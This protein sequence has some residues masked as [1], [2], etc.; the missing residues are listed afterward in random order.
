[1]QITSPKSADSFSIS[2][3]A[4]W[5]SL[6]VQTD[7]T[8]SHT[9]NWTIKWG[10]FTTSGSDVTSGNKWDAAAAITN[11][12]G[13]L[14]VQATANKLTASVSVR[15]KGTNPSAQEVSQY[16]STKANSVGFDKIIAH[17]S[18]FKHFNANGEPIKSFDNGYGM[19]QL[20]FPAPSFEKV[21]NW[22]LNVDGGLSLFSQKRASALTYLGQSQRSYTADQLTYETVCRWNGGHYHEWDAAAGAWVRTASMQCDSATGNIGWDMND[23]SNK[24]KSEADLHKRDSG[25]YS[26][27]PTASSHWRYSGVCYA[28]SVLR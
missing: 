5:P 9:W 15:I 18:K 16:L 28:D 17:E 26:A 27:P 24:G 1:M 22:K 23:I 25:A 2:S 8:G 21:W 10:V 13:L 19:C 20:T 14:T 6:V 12:G 4:A 3:S 7:G 11:L